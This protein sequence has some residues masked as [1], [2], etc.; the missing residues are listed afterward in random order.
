MTKIAVIDVE[1]TGLDKIY[2]VVIE[3]GIVELA[4]ETGKTKVLFDAI[5]REEN[6]NDTHIN[7]WIFDNSNLTYEKIENSPP[8]INYFDEVQDLLVKYQVTAFNIDFDLY[9]LRKSGFEIPFE[10]PCIMKTA[11]NVCKIPFPNNNEHFG[12]REYKWPKVQEAWDFFFPGTV[13]TEKHRAADDAIHE[14]Q[15]CFELYKM[16]RF[17]L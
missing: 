1:T 2:D 14:A 4:L 16:G 7:S 6:F 11:T 13:Y 3:I 12:D 15:I 5:V 10:L 17:R 8:L 9:F